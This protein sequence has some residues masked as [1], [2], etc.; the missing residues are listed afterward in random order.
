MSYKLAPLIED[1]QSSFWFVPSLM[2][3]FSLILAAGTIYI[4]VTHLLAGQGALAFLY[5][6]D[7]QA[8]RSLL[9]T[10][11]GAM[12]TVTSIAFSITI[13]ILTLASSQFGPRLMRNFM[14]DKGT[15]FV[16]GS[17][18]ATFLFCIAVFC[19][20]SFKEPYA[21]KPGITLAVAIAMTCFSVWILIY[22][23]HHVAQSIQADVVIDGVYRELEKTIAKLFPN[24][25]DE[26]DRQEQASSLRGDKGA[27]QL[28]VYSPF[29][30]YLQFTD[31]EC[32][33]NLAVK[34][35]CTIQLHY[36]AGD[37]IVQSATIATVYGNDTVQPDIGEDIVK[38]TVQGAY[39]TP[40]QDPEFAVNQLVEIALRALSPGIN[41]P[42]T[43]ITCIDKLSAVLCNLMAK[44]FPNANVFVDGELRLIC[45]ELTFS[46][47][48]TAAF[49]QIRQHCE[50]NLAV[51][52]KMLDVLHVLA[53]QAKSAEQHDFVFVQTEMIT[54]QQAKQSLSDHDRCEL[55]RR[56]EKITRPTKVV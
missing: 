55:S 8:V 56:I 20:I 31:Q 33:L 11:A 3:L 10:I 4:D 54:Q 37:F 7:V 29:S 51:T 18:I 47:I 5:A 32:L 14:M 45:K 52:I 16:L 50:T 30:G 40:V 39:R 25:S 17:F 23:I 26:D 21:F 36:S 34:S 9:A 41:D 6:N 42:Y 48:A 44:A 49:D 19:A 15:Q 43:A 24:V 12:I 27:C 28:E 38:H 22:F 46:D 1:I 2:M 35:Q 53:C 13:V